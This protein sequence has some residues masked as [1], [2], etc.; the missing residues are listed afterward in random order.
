MSAG[1]VCSTRP[2]K[3][4]P[5]S[6]PGPLVIAMQDLLCNCISAKKYGEKALWR[7]FALG[8]R[9]S[10]CSP[11][12]DNLQKRRE[13]LRRQIFPNFLAGNSAAL[14][15]L[16]R[17][18]PVDEDDNDRWQ[19]DLQRSCEHELL[20]PDRELAD[21]DVHQDTAYHARGNG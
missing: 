12:Q 15:S 19:H 14:A 11:S 7:S 2:K 5:V 3:K 17:E 13:T 4:A 1:R 8:P 9:K 20:I 21:E 10:L 6:Q 18:A 16:L